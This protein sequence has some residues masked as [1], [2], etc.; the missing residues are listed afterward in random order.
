MIFSNIR[1]F[2]D[3]NHSPTSVA[4][5]INQTYFRSLSNTAPITSS[6]Q[7]S[8]ATANSILIIR[9]SLVLTLRSSLCSVRCDIRQEFPFVDVFY[10][11]LW[12]FTFVACFS[13]CIL[14]FLFS[15]SC[16]VV[17]RLLESNKILQRGWFTQRCTMLNPLYMWY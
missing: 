17:C 13:W 6:L 1:V 14:T 5:W 16:V 7:Y 9:H 10:V 15:L 4:S 12:F 8:L 2:S 3:F 11:W